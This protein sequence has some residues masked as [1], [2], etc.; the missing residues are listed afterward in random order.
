[1]LAAVACNKWAG[2]RNT[3]R[4]AKVLLEI[5]NQQRR[6]KV[7]GGGSSSHRERLE[8]EIRKLVLYRD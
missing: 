6:P 1:M 3:H 4:R 2:V 5:D 8:E 7:G